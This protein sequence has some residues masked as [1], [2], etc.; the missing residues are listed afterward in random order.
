MTSI[1]Q[2]QTTTGR[3]CVCLALL[4]FATGCSTYQRLPG[5][6]AATVKSQVDVGDNVKITKING[7]KIEF[8][9][10][11]V[12]NTGVGGEGQFVAYA[13][14]QE[15]RSPQIST[16]AT[17]GVSATVGALLLLFIGLATY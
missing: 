5:T 1:T 4:I 14:I 6:D 8:E 17:V 13:D 15:I 3:L 9:V 7:E 10:S 11:E 12:S 2:V 16:G